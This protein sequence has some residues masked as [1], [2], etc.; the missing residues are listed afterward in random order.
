MIMQFLTLGNSLRIFILI[1]AI[2]IWR[3]MFPSRAEPF[4]A[5]I[6]NGRYTLNIPEDFKKVTI[7][8]KKY[9]VLNGM[10]IFVSRR[11][12]QIFAARALDIGQELTPDDI[13]QLF[14]AVTDQNLLNSQQANVAAGA[15]TC[16]I[17]TFF[18]AA[19][20]NYQHIA[21]CPDGNRALIVIDFEKG[22]HHG[23]IIEFITSIEVNHSR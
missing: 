7:N 14:E 1:I 18:F 9:A 23:D 3:A 15:F 2:I 21:L 5:Q 11:S 4:K 16:S 17:K 6:D 19:T 8:D 20:K 13:E 22:S 10:D 12:Q